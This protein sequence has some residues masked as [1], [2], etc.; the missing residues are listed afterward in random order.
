MYWPFF[1]EK[2]RALFVF[3]EWWFDKKEVK[4]PDIENCNNLLTSLMASLPTIT[5][6]PCHPTL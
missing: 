2:S 3:S 5:P 1:K 4:G 6:A